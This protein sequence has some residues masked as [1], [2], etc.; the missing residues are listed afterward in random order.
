MLKLVEPSP[1]A[2]LR[3]ALIASPAAFPDLDR[4]FAPAALKEDFQLFVTQ[5]AS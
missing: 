1:A 3:A 2:V 5:F 4:M